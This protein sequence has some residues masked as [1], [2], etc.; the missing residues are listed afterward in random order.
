MCIW[1]NT[2][3]TTGKIKREP[4][5]S[6]KTSFYKRWLHALRHTSPHSNK[7]PGPPTLQSGTSLGYQSC[8]LD[9]PWP[10]VSE[11]LVPEVR[12][13][14]FRRD[15]LRLVFT[16]SVAVEQHLSPCLH[17]VQLWSCYS[18]LNFTPTWNQ[19][20]CWKRILHESVS[21]CFTKRVFI[22]ANFQFRRPKT[23]TGCSGVQGGRTGRR[24]RHP[25]SE[26]RKL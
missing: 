22:P 25:K 3:S 2:F 21:L 16:K 14:Y 13:V 1:V 17:L 19:Q 4:C 26:I 20:A 15:A 12:S 24:P 8:L 9:P 11:K 10:K 5:E 23:T 6:A 7:D 18:T